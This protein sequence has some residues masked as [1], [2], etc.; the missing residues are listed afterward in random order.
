ML[1]MY[2]LQLVYCTFSLLSRERF[3]AFQVHRICEQDTA[4]SYFLTD[5]YIKLKLY[6]AAL[7]DR[8]VSLLT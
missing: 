4:V 2:I 6:T 8:R 1:F 5:K 3:I 7:S